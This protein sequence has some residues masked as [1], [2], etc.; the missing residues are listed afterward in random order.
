MHKESQTLTNQKPQFGITFLCLLSIILTF[1]SQLCRC[2]LQKNKTASVCS[3]SE[4]AG[5]MQPKKHVNDLKEKMLPQ[6]AFHVV[7]I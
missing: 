6:E 5:C 7:K 1:D 2:G 3:P 4:F